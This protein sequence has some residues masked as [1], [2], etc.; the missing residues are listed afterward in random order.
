M[1]SNKYV[2]FMDELFEL[3]V[4]QKGSDLHLK[5]DANPLIRIDG[6]LV[7]Q[8]DYPVLASENIEALIYSILTQ[9]QKDAFE[10]QLELDFSYVVKDNLRFRGNLVKERGNIGAVFRV[11]PV[12][13]PTLEELNLPSQLHD[14]SL[15]RRGLVLVTGP[16]GQRKVH[17]T[18]K[19]D[20][21]HK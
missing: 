2:E 3:T 9:E 11:I 6:E 16:Y 7:P 13:I 21:I 8:E 10:N 5:A 19:H 1:E 20:R 4:K 17:N 15:T 18:L 12:D 14:I